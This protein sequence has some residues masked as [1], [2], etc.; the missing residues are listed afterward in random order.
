MKE[1][2]TLKVLMGGMALVFCGVILLVSAVLLKLIGDYLRQEGRLKL[3]RLSRALFI[4][5]LLPFPLF[6]GSIFYAARIE[7]YWIATRTVNVASPLFS[8]NLKNVKIVQISDLHI[9]EIRPYEKGLIRR[10]N[11]LKPDLLFITG[12]FINEAD[13]VELVLEVLGQMKAKYGI[14]AVLGNN[15]YYYL[16]EEDFI[17]ALRR[18]GVRAL[19]HENLKIDLGDKGSFWL[20]GL[21]YRYGAEPY[22]KQAF[23]G[24]PVNEPKILIT[25][26]PD[27]VDINGLADFD[28]QI[29]MAGHTHG[30]QIGIPFIRRL[31]DKAETSRYMAGGHVT[32]KGLLLYV[33]RG[34]ATTIPAARFLCRPEI[35]VYKLKHSERK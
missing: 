32:D 27:V 6:F 9:S 26:D 31:S 35:T 30:G 4:L 22:L 18:A 1:F 8:Q 16:N 14:Y 19:K 11:R 13:D 23:A 24:V 10:I 33:N 21:S 7:P 17:R 20:A 12:D 28:P 5:A 15:E 3:Y 25:H 34:I 29:V 2:A